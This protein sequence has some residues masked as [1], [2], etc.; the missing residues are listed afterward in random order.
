MVGV[1]PIGV[2]TILEIDVGMS[3]KVCLHCRRDFALMVSDCV[4]I[5]A[6]WVGDYYFV[7][8]G[9]VFEGCRD[10]FVLHSEVWVA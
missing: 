8:V 7:D 5:Y 9:M 6:H 3:V 10:L 1:S 2:G 4:F